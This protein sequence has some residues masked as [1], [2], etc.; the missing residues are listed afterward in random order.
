MTD[1]KV[2]LPLS[3]RDDFIWVAVS[4]TR[5]GKPSGGLV[6]LFTNKEEAIAQI[7]KQASAH[8]VWEFYYRYVSLE[9]WHANCFNHPIVALGEKGEKILWF[10]WKTDPAVDDTDAPDTGSYVACGCPEWAKQTIG[11]S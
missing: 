10:E 2:E 9:K 3:V 11:W 5:E 1:V 4:H 8:Q 7:T 6:G